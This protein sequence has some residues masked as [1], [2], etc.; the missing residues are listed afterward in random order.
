MTARFGLTAQLPAYL[1]LAA[2]AVA[3]AMIDIDVKRLPNAIVLPSYVVAAVLLL[4][5]AVAGDDWGPPRGAPPRWR[6]C[7]PPTSRSPRSCPA[8]WA[9]A[10]SSWPAC[11]GSTSAGSA[12][13]R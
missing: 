4:I 11:S 12:G 5:A 10:T 13:A 2:V 7:G 9:S 3:L 1:Y 8:G 6:C